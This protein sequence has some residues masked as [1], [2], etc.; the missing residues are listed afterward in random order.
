MVRRSTVVAVLLITSAGIAG[1]S[2]LA[3]QGGVDSR[4]PNA[5]SQKPAFAS[6]TRA[7]EAKANVAFEV[8]TVSVGLDHPWGL[9][10]IPSGRMLVTERPGRLRVVAANGTLS[11]AVTGLP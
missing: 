7:P 1:Y 4:V 5:T 9:A 11:A 2:V 3:T 8:R 6:Q 10:F